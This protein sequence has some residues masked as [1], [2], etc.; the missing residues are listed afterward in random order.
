MSGNR[1]CRYTEHD[2]FFSLMEWGEE[3]DTPSYGLANRVGRIERRP[4]WLV[5][6]VTFGKVGGH[7]WYPQGRA[8]V[9]EFIL[10]FVTDSRRR[11]L[12]FRN[13]QMHD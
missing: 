9:P 4:A 5:R 7:A 1:V 6:A 11:V 2:G 8:P 13:T 3:L 10:W 12:E